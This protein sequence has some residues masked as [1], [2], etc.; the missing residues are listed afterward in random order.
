MA[1]MRGAIEIKRKAL[2]NRPEGLA[3]HRRKWWSKKGACAQPLF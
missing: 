3:I 1:H 2:P